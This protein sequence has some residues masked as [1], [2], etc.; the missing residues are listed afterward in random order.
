V[1]RVN[2]ARKQLWQYLS[3][4]EPGTPAETLRARWRAAHVKTV[5]CG[6]QVQRDDGGWETV[7]C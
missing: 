4:A 1:H 6:G 2:R 7:S 5:V 3:D